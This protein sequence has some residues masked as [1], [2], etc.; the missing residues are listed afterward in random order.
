MID[1]RKEDLK[2][3]VRRAD[4]MKTLVESEGWN[5]LMVPHL[6]G[7]KVASL[8]T[9]LTQAQ[10]IEE[11]METKQTFNVAESVLTW[12]G[13]VVAL[14]EAAKEELTS[15]EFAGETADLPN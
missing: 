10:S 13:R 6:E 1:E 7:I 8:K 12:P 15:E 3:R 5:D 2:D 4:K 9:W 11:F 14:G